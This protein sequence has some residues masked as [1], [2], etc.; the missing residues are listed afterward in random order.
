MIKKILA[1]GWL[2]LV[3]HIG[4]AQDGGGRLEA[5]KIAF[6]T[7]KLNLSSEEA[8]KFWPVY[9]KYVDEIRQV[10]RENRNKDELELEEKIVN[11]RK[12]Y[13]NE[14]GQAISADRVNQ[15]FK[16]DKEFSNTVLKE[17]QDRQ[18]RN[19]GKNSF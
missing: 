13:K 1:I 9:N 14:F 15:F 2:L 8:Q 16:F 6:L 19:P 7:K 10:R 5:Y 3:A 11:V 4:F 18:G 17:W 12:K